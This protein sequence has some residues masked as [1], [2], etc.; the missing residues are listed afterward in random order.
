MLSTIQI[1]NN[2]NNNNNNNKY[3]KYYKKN[4]SINF[5]P[6]L[7]HVYLY[8]LYIYLKSLESMNNLTI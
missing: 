7:K 1:Q 8:C 3:Y 4:S 2:N 5:V 6:K